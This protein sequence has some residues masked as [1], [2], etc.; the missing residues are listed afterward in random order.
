MLEIDNP[1]TGTK[2]SGPVL[3]SKPCRVPLTLYS[4]LPSIVV[5]AVCNQLVL[6]RPCFFI[7]WPFPAHTQIPGELILFKLLG[8]IYFQAI[9]CPMFRTPLNPLGVCTSTRPLDDAYIMKSVP[10]RVCLPY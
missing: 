3:V 2:L 7:A 5:S 10:Q 9:D 4:D 6:N 8:S 1:S